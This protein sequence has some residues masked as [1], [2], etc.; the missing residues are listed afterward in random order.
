MF[1]MV[2]DSLTLCTS[3]A[4]ISVSAKDG[5]CNY[6]KLHR[7]LISMTSLKGFEDFSPWML[8]RYC[9]NVHMTICSHSY[10]LVPWPESLKIFFGWNQSKCL[11]NSQFLKTQWQQYQNV[12]VRERESFQGKFFITSIIA[13]KLDVADTRS[14][15]PFILLVIDLILWWY[16]YDSWLDFSLILTVDCQNPKIQTLIHSKISA[17]ISTRAV[18]PTGW[19]VKIPKSS[20]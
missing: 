20:E 18:A 6:H 19:P 5:K 3:W 7:L 8:I 14:A 17:Q 9:T 4:V 16:F 12:C 13:E 1:Q 11:Q 2:I 15:N 10:F